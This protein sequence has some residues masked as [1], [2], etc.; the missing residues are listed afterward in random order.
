MTDAEIIFTDSGNKDFLSLAAQL[1]SELYARDGDMA[2]ENA[3]LNKIGHLPNVALLFLHGRAIACGGFVEY[4]HESVE[5]KRMYV[6]P[7]GRNR[8]F[9]SMILHAL[10]SAARQQG[11]KYCILETGLN[12][13][14]AIAFYQKYKYRETA[15]FGKYKDSLNSVCFFKAL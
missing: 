3:A 11:Y 13:P 4:D 12:Q 15:K 2:E 5:L 1:E 8:N 7:A 14:E 10:E 9:A 6:I